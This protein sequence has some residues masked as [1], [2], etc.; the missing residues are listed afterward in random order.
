MYA[1]SHLALTCKCAPLSF[2][3]PSIQDARLARES[4]RVPV[5]LSTP[6]S[7]HLRAFKYLIQFRLELSFLH[8]FRLILT[9]VK[10]TCPLVL[11]TWKELQRLKPRKI[12]IKPWKRPQLK[13]ER[14]QEQRTLRLARAYMFWSLRALS[15]VLLLTKNELEFSAGSCSSLGMQLGT[16]HAT[17]ECERANLG[18]SHV[19]RPTTPRHKQG[20]ASVSWNHHA[21][22]SSTFSFLF[23]ELFC[24][25]W[26][27]H[28]KAVRLTTLQYFNWRLA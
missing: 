5:W 6:K 3:P 16:S 26:R 22:V 20:K 11:P 12:C 10:D 9:S 17:Q 25:P 21:M 13:Q 4:L 23:F 2:F 7:R 24:E 15:I 27:D 1:P 14:T 19:E 8:R 28:P 18:M